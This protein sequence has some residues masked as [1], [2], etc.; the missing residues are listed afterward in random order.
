MGRSVL[1]AGLCFVA[2]GAAAQGG[3]PRLSVEAA[4]RAARSAEPDPQRV[5]EACLND[6]KTALGELQNGPWR[7]AKAS[8]R[9]TCLANQRQSGA[10]SYVELLGCVQLMEGT[11]IRPTDPK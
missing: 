2:F 10:Q 5:Y 7:N 9:E 6:E 1:I 4:C 8:S 3:V 11:T